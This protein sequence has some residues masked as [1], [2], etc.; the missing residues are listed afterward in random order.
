MLDATPLLRAYARARLAQLARL[1][2]VAAQ[3]HTL[4][5]LLRAAR[6]T[7]FGAAHGFAAIGSVADYQARV[8]LRRYEDFWDEWWQP[9]FPQLR[10]ITWPDAIP[11]FAYTSG[12]ERGVTKYIPVSRAMTRANR[13]A[14][15]DVLAFHVASRPRS[16][17]LGGRQLVLGGSTKLVDLA[18]GVRGGDLSGIAALEV[19]WWARSRY[20]PRRD[21]ALLA[22]W[23]EKT[24]RLAPLSLAADVRSIAGTPSWMLLFFEQLARLHPERGRTLAAFYPRLELIIHGGVSFAPYRERFAAWLGDSRAETREVYPASEG[25]IAVADRGP[26][27]GL[28]L[29]LDNGLF[30]E[31]VPLAELDRPAPRRAWIANA[32]IGVDYALAVTSNAGLWSCLL[33]DTV[34]LVERDPPRVLVT[35][36]IAHDLSVFG[37]HLTSRELDMAIAAA[38]RAIGASVADYAAAATLDERDSRGRHLFI[39]EFAD[40]A[41]GEEP[42]AAFARTLDAELARQNADYADHRRNDF[43]VRPPR[44]HAVPPGTFAAWMRRRGRLG[45]QNKVPRVIR[46]PDLLQDLRHFVG[47]A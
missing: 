7:R 27:E 15:L 29:I 3:T 34:T 47:D 21:L 13:R 31:L 6:A 10:G 23:E 36:R 9:H 44:V 8:R 32:E 17:I 1:D 28:R 35:G 40:P 20:F 18:P 5:M 42:A 14:A 24:A 12:T 16:R 39:V 46:D 4:M 11:Y 2:P 19:P 41:P 37:E 26:D 25:F 30:L 22:D 38:A 33:G 45:G 43:G